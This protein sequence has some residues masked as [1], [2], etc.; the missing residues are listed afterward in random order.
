MGEI[1]GP[2]YYRSEKGDR[3]HYGEADFFAATGIYGDIDGRRTSTEVMRRIN[4]VVGKSMKPTG[5]SGLGEVRNSHT[6]RAHQ[7][8][9]YNGP[10]QVRR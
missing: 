1:I 9:G 4:F 8:N 10:G 2:V 5:V 7:S 3:A 6:S